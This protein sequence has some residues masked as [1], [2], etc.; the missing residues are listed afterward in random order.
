MRYIPIAKQNIND[1][2]GDSKYVATGGIS[3]PGSIGVRWR[4]SV[5]L[6]V[7]YQA[8]GVF[9]GTCQLPTLQSNPKVTKIIYLDLEEKKS[10]AT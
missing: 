1:H 3:Y 4:V 7:L 10:H 9:G 6:Y 2:R 5:K 8:P